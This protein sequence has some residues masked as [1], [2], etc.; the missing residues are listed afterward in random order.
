MY[1]LVLIYDDAF[2]DK[3][4][5]RAVEREDG[6]WGLEQILEEII[7]DVH[8]A[9]KWDEYEKVI[10]TGECVNDPS[11]VILVPREKGKKLVKKLK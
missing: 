1:D 9:L 10:L 7:S 3:Y 6:I 5:E 8:I 4:C 2:V 11:K